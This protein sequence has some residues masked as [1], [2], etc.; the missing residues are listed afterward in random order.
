MC[1]WGG[2]EANP[3]LCII[4]SSVACSLHILEKTRVIHT[5]SLV[6]TLWVSCVSALVC[7]CTGGGLKLVLCIFLNLIFCLS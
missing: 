3:V 6:L 1:V 5:S 2:A 7:V 4:N